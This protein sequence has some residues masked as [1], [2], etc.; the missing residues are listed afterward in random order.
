MFSNILL[1]QD[2]PRMTHDNS[3]VKLHQVMINLLTSHIHSLNMCHYLGQ[4]LADQNAL[5]MFSIT[6]PKHSSN[7]SEFQ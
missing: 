7:L 4:D 6:P 2:V 5:V 1:C 3:S